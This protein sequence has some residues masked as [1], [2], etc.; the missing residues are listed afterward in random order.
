MKRFFTYLLL[1]IFILAIVLIANT[2]RQTS[3]QM[4]NVPAL[5]S[6]VVS[7]SAASHLSQAV[8]FRTVSFLDANLMDSTQFEK[9]I[10]FL[11]KTYPLAHAKLKHQ[12]VGGFSL[13]FEWQGSDVS[14]KPAMLMGHYDVVPVIQ[15][16]ERMWKNMPFAGKI[17]NG[18]VYGRGT[19]DDKS[20]VMG[21]LE[22]VE[23]LLQQ[24]YQPKRTHYLSFGHDE[25]IGGNNG[26]K[27]V[28]ALLKSKNIT[29]EYGIDEGG[30]VKTDGLAGLKKPIALVGISEKGYTSL[31]LTATGEGGHS[32]MPPSFTSIGILAEAIDKLQKHPFPA[33]IQGATGAMF[34]YLAPE[35][36]FVN[37]MVLSNRWLLGSVVMKSMISTPSGNATLRNT[38]SPTMIN[39]GIKDNVLPIEAS[40]IIN[41][42]IMPNDSVQGI[43]NYVKKTIDN[44]KIVVETLKKSDTNPSPV[45]DT[46]SVGFKKIQRTIM[47]CFPNVVVAPYLVVGGTDAKHFASICPNMFRFMPVEFTDQDIKLL[48]GTNEKISIKDF[49]KVV[50][51]YVELIKSE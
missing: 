26:A 3:R 21:I 40:A 41:F 44:D 34:D 13:L 10:S 36:P 2:F 4:T 14:L 35:M 12:R 15:G 25:E 19:L 33:S 42:R 22:A 7:D 46:A 47:G 37:R 23:Q 30:T 29:L 38:I 31:R 48:H 8:R 51:F 49:K 24:N 16:T 32:S 39:A 6:M 1:G 5:A 28:A 45:S 17:S 50:Q 20:T 27:N 43:V 9:F 18:Y 11:E